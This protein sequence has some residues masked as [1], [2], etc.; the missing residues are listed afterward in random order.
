MAIKGQSFCIGHDTPILIYGAS[1]IGS[2]TGKELLR[3][4]YNV[5]GF[6][7]KRAD[8]IG[9]CLG[10]PVYNLYELKKTVE[11]DAVIFIA[12]KNVYYHEGI[13]KNLN[14]L[15]F[16]HVIYKSRKAVS[17]K[18]GQEEKLLDNAYEGIYKKG[19]VLSIHMPVIKVKNEIEWKSNIFMKEDAENVTVKIPAELL[20]TGVTDSVWM[21]VPVL[22]LIPYLDMFRYFQGQDQYS[23][24]DY[25]ALCQKGAESENLKITEGWKRYV[26]EN[27][28]NIYEQMYLKYEF[29]PEYFWENAPRVTLNGERHFIIETGKHRVCFLVAIGMT[30]IPVCLRRVDWERFLDDKA[31]DALKKALGNY[32]D[33]RIPIAHP[34]FQENIRF[35][36]FRQQ[37]VLQKI[38]RILYQKKLLIGSGKSVDVVVDLTGTAGYYARFFSGIGMKA[39]MDRESGNCADEINSLFRSDICDCRECDTDKAVIIVDEETEMKRVEG[40]ALDKYYLFQTDRTQKVCLKEG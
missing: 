6:I 37:I 36:S 31:V 29:E 23:A 40:L 2:V 33:I 1:Y 20:Y 18:M 14:S 25:V 28:R 4:K 17:G 12:V 21:N 5:I 24:D 27:R 10:V 16:Y 7:D 9:T 34:L 30:S 11:R 19:N 13:V 15:G 38:L 26:L 35:S 22:Q 39:F 8:E 3:K 32:S